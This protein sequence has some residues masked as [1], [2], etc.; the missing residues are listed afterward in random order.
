[1]LALTVKIYKVCTVLHAWYK[2]LTGVLSTVNAVCKQY[3]VVLS[4]SLPVSLFS[5]AVA[6]FTVTPLAG[7]DASSILT[8]TTDEASSSATSES[9]SESLQKPLQRL[10]SPIQLPASPI[11]WPTCL[12]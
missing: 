1:M 10:R 9:S 6:A 12:P 11:R 5:L 2:P 3:N 7:L 4:I 8:S